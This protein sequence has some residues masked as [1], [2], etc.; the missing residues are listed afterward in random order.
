MPTTSIQPVP[1][2]NRPLA[3]WLTGVILAACLAWVYWPTL[4][5]LSR[6]WANDPK[7]SHGYFVPLFAVY[8]AWLRCRGHREGSSRPSWWGLPLLIGGLLL[9]WAGTY[10]YIPWFAS[11][12][13]LP[14]AAALILLVGGGAVFRRS[15]PAVGFLGLILPLP[16]RLGK[17]PARPLHRLP[18]VSSV[19]VLQTLGF[20]AHTEGN[21][22]C[23]RQERVN[24]VEACNGLS[25]MMM[26]FALAAAVVLLARR[27]VLD[28]L[29]VLFS[30]VPIA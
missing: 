17:A 29:V 16:V 6:L 23:L 27:P 18:S 26:F 21:V 4:T 19:Y 24:V 3:V 28:K 25:M 10:F 1:S 13:L 8:L 14:L 11:A 5:E 12:S 2:S 30:A 7:Y 15:W 20:P 22:I 9:R